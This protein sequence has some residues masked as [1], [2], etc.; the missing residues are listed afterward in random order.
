MRTKG[1]KLT[2][3]GFLKGAT[4]ASG[5]LLANSTGISFAEKLP[6]VNYLRGAQI[7]T[8]TIQINE[9]P[10][11]AGFEA[12]VKKY[13]KDT[14]NDVKLNVMP[15][16]GML[17]KSRNAVQS[18]ESEFDILNLNEQWYM[19]FY[20]GGLVTPIKDIKSDFEIDP[21][22]IEYDSATRWDEAVRYSSPNGE[23]YGL[24]I[25]GNIQLFFY[26]KDLF[27]AQGIEVPTTWDEVAQAAEVFN[28]P[29][30]MF[31]FTLRTKPPNWQFQAYLESYGTSVL[32]LSED[33]VWS[34]GL[35]PNEAALAALNEWLYLGRTY[36]P[37]N[38]ADL[39]QAENI[40]L[41]QSGRLAMAHMVGAA[42]PN[43][44]NPD[45]SVVVG[46]MGSSVVPGGPKGRATMS[47]I[48]VMSI[49]HNLPDVRKSSALAFLE[50]AL[51][52][53]A[54]LYYAQAGAIPVRQD[55]YEEMGNDPKLGWWM[56]GMAD[57][58]PYI[59][60]QPRLNETPQIVDVIDRRVS[61]ALIN[62][63]T[64][65]EALTESAKELE[66]ILKEGGYKYE[67]LA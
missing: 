55:V 9:S 51:T 41:M 19:Q 29:P 37:P 66:A 6:T 58:T 34:I 1:H 57:S 45:Q 20:A 38:I 14:G 16:N 5:V 39:G 31:G 48:W 54:Q 52:K 4:A 28:N 40:A 23:I 27:D 12:L 65:E 35:G 22:V 50:W 33:G 61:Q 59:K 64:P 46:K 10:W 36:G 43:F 44:D 60:A 32:N 42:A 2:R 17:E 67:P 25:N 63:L 15:F 11:F 56:Q 7:E 18:D 24:P 13:V 49:P 8:I 30:Q 21:N 53:D 26:R 47:G 3:R 62:E